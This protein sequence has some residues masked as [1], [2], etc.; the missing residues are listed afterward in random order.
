MS[1]LLKGTFSVEQS[2]TGNMSI[3]DF[4]RLIEDWQQLLKG[5]ISENTLPYRIKGKDLYVA[6]LHPTLAQELTFMER[7]IM[8]KILKS[9]P[10][11]S[12]K[13]GRIHFKYYPGF[14][15][16]E[17]L[18]SLKN[19]KSWQP[20]KQVIVADVVPDLTL[21]QKQSLKLS[22]QSI[23]DLEIKKLLDLLIDKL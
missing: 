21:Q 12:R 18:T 8:L 13:L 5:F 23:G 14:D 9:Y 10:E 3:R 20:S 6:T 2:P 17:Y 7:D 19:G 15:I 4:L 22:S 1:D 11:W 16:Q